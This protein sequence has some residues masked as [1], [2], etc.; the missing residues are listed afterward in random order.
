[1]TDLLRDYARLVIAKVSQLVDER[2]QLVI[3][4]HFGC[5]KFPEQLHREQVTVTVQPEGLGHRYS[6][7]RKDLQIGTFLVCLEATE[8]KTEVNFS[9]V[10]VLLP[11]PVSK[12]TMPADYV[13]C[14][15]KQV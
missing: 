4:G 12:I 9:K 11:K 14:I 2:L 13:V 5:W 10:E 6:V 7:W 1:M 15:D 3:M 8:K